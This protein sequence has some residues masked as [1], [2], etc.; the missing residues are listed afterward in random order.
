MVKRMPAE[1]AEVFELKIVTAL[2]C[3]ALRFL[4]YVL[5]TDM[6]LICVPARRGAISAFYELAFH[7]GPRSYYRVKSCKKL[8]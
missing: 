1:L 8:A 7:L 5:S 4:S 6:L 2:L 3:S